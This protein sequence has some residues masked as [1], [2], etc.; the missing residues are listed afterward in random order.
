MPGVVRM[1]RSRSSLG[2]DRRESV[3]RDGETGDNH[4]RWESRDTEPTRSVTRADR[5]VDDAIEVREAERPGAQVE[6]YHP[7]P[8]TYLL[9]L[10][11]EP[12]T[13]R[14][15]GR[16]VGGRGLR[17]GLRHEAEQEAAQIQADAVRRTDRLMRE[18]RG[19]TERV[20][21]RHGSRPRIGNRPGTPTRRSSK[22]SGTTSPRLP[23]R[24]FRGTP[25][26]RTT[27]RP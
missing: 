15:R 11:R 8:D 19:G 14:T 6:G 27:A 24:P 12:G 22:R 3:Q 4:V 2:R 18:G 26:D 17:R 9:G 20:R 10:R 7:G 21:R 25:E 1:R 5:R 13:H 16:R 23:S